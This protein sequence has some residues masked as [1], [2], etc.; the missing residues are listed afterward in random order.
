MQRRQASLI[1][2]GKSGFWGGE[3][4]KVILRLKYQ[5]QQP[6]L[7]LGCDG[8]VEKNFFCGKEVPRKMLQAAERR[9]RG[10]RDDRQTGRGMSLLGQEESYYSKGR[11][12]GAD[13]KVTLIGIPVKAQPKKLL[14]NAPE[15][16]LLRGNVQLRK[17]S[18]GKK[19]EPSDQPIM[20]PTGRNGIKRAK[21]R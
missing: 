13:K 20:D 6:D 16:E 15:H 12:R 18:Q 5:T 11:H 2:K 7:L 19:K 3:K 14:Y 1:V 9:C 4:K 8:G 17:G 21:L 10:L